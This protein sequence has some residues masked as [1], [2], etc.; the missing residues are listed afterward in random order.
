MKREKKYRGDLKFFNE[1]IHIH[2]YL[3]SIIYGGLDGIITTFAVVAGVAGA[4]LTSGIILILGFAN[5]FADG[6]SMA[7]SDYL[8]TKAL[9]EYEGDSMRSNIPL[10]SAFYTFISFCFFGL[11]PLLAFILSYFT[12]IQNPLIFSVVF[13]LISLFLLGVFKSR[14]TG[15]HPLMSALETLVIGGLAAGMAYSVGYFVASL[16]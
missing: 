5:L 9:R 8:S 2:R 10:K 4:S 15:K 11:I 12:K 3:K 14:I 1:T 13:T 7:V 16:I 6:F